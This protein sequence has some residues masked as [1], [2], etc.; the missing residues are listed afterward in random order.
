MLAHQVLVR[1]VY[2]MCVLTCTCSARPPAWWTWGWR[3][4]MAT[5]QCTHLLQLATRTESEEERDD[6][7]ISGAC[8]P[9]WL[10]EHNSWCHKLNQ[11]SRYNWIF[12][13]SP[14]SIFLS[15]IYPTQPQLFQLNLSLLSLLY[16]P[17][18]AF[19]FVVWHLTP[20]ASLYTIA[21]LW[22][23][24]DPYEP[25]S[26]AIR[27]YVPILGPHSWRLSINQLVKQKIQGMQKSPY[28]QTYSL[29]FLERN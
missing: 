5:A 12:S 29:T 27:L 8:C 1:H 20:T 28:L 17:K 26:T 14:S 19:V 10:A 4:L 21:V 7:A 9:R 22:F 3:W 23:C 15:C 11:S 25:V 24:H 2:S 6:Q 16:L 18:L 13:I